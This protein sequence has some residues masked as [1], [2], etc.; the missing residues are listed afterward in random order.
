MEEHNKCL[1]GF[2]LLDKG[3][4]IHHSLGGKRKHRFLF[5]CH[6]VTRV[7]WFTRFRHIISHRSTNKF[8]FA[9]LFWRRVSYV[10]IIS[11][12]C[13]IESPSQPPR[14]LRTS[15]WPSNSVLL[16]HHALTQRSAAL[17]HQV[18][19]VWVVD[20][21]RSDAEVFDSTAQMG[22]LFQLVQIWNCMFLLIQNMEINSKHIQVISL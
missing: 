21:T 15:T 5:K 14:L 13:C 11:N 4:I 9:P 2:Y 10:L 8:I 1:G 16:I 18:S 3:F 12:H 7:F 19:G 6:G 17:I 22:R 20:Y